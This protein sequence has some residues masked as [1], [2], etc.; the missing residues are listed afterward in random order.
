MTTDVVAF[1]RGKAESWAVT[2]MLYRTVLSDRR[3]IASFTLTLP[4]LS[5]EKNRAP[6]PISSVYNT[7]N[8]NIMTMKMKSLSHF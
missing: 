1:M 5:T 2:S 8:N 7:N 6:Y 4:A 3:L